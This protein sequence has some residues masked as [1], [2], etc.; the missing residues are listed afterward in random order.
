[1][2][3]SVFGI[4]ISP[5]RLHVVVRNIIYSMTYFVQAMLTQVSSN[6]SFPSYNV[7]LGF[8]GAYCAFSK[9]GRA[10]FGLICFQL[11]ALLLDII[12]CAVNGSA[13]PSASFKFALTMLIFCLVAKLAVLYSASHFFSAIGGA[14]AMNSSY[15]MSAYDSMGTFMIVSFTE[16]HT[17]RL[18]SVHCLSFVVMEEEGRSHSGGG[19]Y[20]NPPEQH[21]DDQRGRNGM[22]LSSSHSADGMWKIFALL[23]MSYP[24]VA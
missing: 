2:V 20:Y 13:D 4:F 15:T 18:M 24:N 7:V 14:Y 6:H 1:M 8:W 9:H 19:A 22:P 3:S 17:Y 5:S 21:D 16:L 12:F 23:L 11:L 10:T